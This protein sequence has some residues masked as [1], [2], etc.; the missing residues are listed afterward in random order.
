MIQ[1]FIFLCAVVFRFF[2]FS[3][4]SVRLMLMRRRLEKK[5]ENNEG[6]LS[7]FWS[8]FFVMFAEVFRAAIFKLTACGSPGSVNV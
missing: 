8:F 3:S 2:L 5:E 6:V 7:I 1:K 4:R